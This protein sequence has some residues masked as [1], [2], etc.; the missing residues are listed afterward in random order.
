MAQTDNKTVLLV[1]DEEVFLRTVADGFALFA[2]QVT[3]LTAPNGK[4]AVDVL[5]RHRVD[6]VVTDLKM[7]EMDGFGLI[8]HMSRHNPGVPIIVMSAFGTLDIESR[9][10]EQG[11]VQFLDKP[12]DFQ[13]L[14]DKVVSALA[15]SAS[16]HLSGIALSTVLQMIEADRK[17]CTVR[18]SAHGQNGELVFKG[19]LLADAQTGELHGAG[20][21]MDIVCWSEPEIDILPGPKSVSK[22]LEMP[23]TQILLEAFRAKDERERARQRDRRRTRD[24][25]HATP[26]PSRRSAPPA[27]RGS[28]PAAA[29]KVTSSTPLPEPKANQKDKEPINMSAQEKLKELSS[30]DGFTGAA[31]YT[32]QG[33]LLAIHGGESAN[34]KDIGVLANNVLMNA[35]KA[36]LE[37][38]TGRGQQV[39]VEAE[40]SHILVRCL[41]EGTDPLRSQPNK[42][43]IH[44]VLVLKPD[45]PIGLAKLRTN[46]VIQ[47]LAEDFRM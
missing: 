5:S 18:V 45:A 46:S 28:S 24:E 23:V 32:P 14:A 12:V 37:M 47:K 16:G 39:H 38:G 17:T 20:A 19:G 9:L 6:L 44:M 21:A 30:I 34:F 35:Q 26:V 25:A 10:E 3:L 33:E 42:A 2:D 15:A 1:D 8:A 4:V 43:H 29:V 11:I 41:N 22:T 36:S 27:A 31:I 13:Q 40:G 7:P